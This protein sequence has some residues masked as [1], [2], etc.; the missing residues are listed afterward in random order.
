MAE[1]IERNEIFLKQLMRHEGAKQWRFTDLSAAQ[2]ESVR[3]VLMEALSK[4]YL[5]GI[6]RS[7]WSLRDYAD[8][9]AYIS[10]YHCRWRRL[11]SDFPPPCVVYRFNCILRKHRLLRVLRARLGENMPF[12]LEVHY[13]GTKKRRDWNRDHRADSRKCDVCPRCGADAMN[14]YRTSRQES[15]IVRY[16]RC[17]VCKH[18]RVWLDALQAKGWLGMLF[19]PPCG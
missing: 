4:R 7:G 12:G 18:K 11:P 6:S 10:R 17:K 19:V 9:L 5:T 14:C 15:R 3:S 16:Y 1:A 13:R 2:W 8:A